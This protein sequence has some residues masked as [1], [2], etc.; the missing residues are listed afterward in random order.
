MRLILARSRD[1]FTRRA[2]REK[3]AKNCQIVPSV[4]RGKRGRGDLPAKKL[5][6]RHPHYP[7]PRHLAIAT[8][9]INLR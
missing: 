7:L 8:N 9:P 1:M 4:D 2:C 6:L 3:D 5:S